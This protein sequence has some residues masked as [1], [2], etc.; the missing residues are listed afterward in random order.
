MMMVGLLAWFGDILGR[1]VVSVSGT[2]VLVVLLVVVCSV[3]LP[4]G[5]LRFC[6]TRGILSQPFVYKSLLLHVVDIHISNG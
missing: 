2:L 3:I 5:R 1:V 6:H 4:C